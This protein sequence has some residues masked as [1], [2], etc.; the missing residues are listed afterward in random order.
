[1]IAFALEG[2]TYR[3]ERRSERKDIRCDEQIGVR[4]SYRMPVDAV[5]SYRDLGY[6]IGACK[7]DALRC[8]TAQCDPPDYPVRRVNPLGVKEAAKLLGLVFRGHGRCQSHS[9]SFRASPLDAPPR[10][11]PCAAA[12][13]A[14]VA[15]GRRTVEA[16]LQRQAIAWQ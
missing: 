6:Q 4:S 9:E 16:D 15:L 7:G 5:R 2:A 3:G 13:L 10:T 1:M 12:T 11:R 8:E 14:V